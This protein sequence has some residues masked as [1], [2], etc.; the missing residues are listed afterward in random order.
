MELASVKGKLEKNTLKAVS[1]TSTTQREMYPIRC[2]SY[3][4]YAKPNFASWYLMEGN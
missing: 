1:N 3:T 4:R 2:L